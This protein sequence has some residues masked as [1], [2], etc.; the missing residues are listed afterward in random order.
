MSQEQRTPYVGEII[1]FKSNPDD[2]IAQSNHHPGPIPAIV[3]RVWSHGCVNCK[4]IPDCGPMQDRTSVVHHSLN[5]AGYHFLFLD[6]SEEAKEASNIDVNR[7]GDEV[8]DASS[9]LSKHE[10]DA[11]RTHINLNTPMSI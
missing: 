5:H 4:I 6:E 9:F 2:S 1:L 3:T 10:V 7:S 11:I 8:K